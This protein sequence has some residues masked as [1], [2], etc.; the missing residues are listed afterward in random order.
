MIVWKSLLSLGTAVSI[1][2]AAPLARAGDPAEDSPQE[3][4]EE[5]MRS[6]L[7][8]LELLLMSIPQYAAPEVLPNGDIIIRRVRP[9]PGPGPDGGSAP[10]AG[11]AAT[12]EART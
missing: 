9:E 5:G 11:G 2:L 8:A 4:L 3:M 6:I 7:G 12:D 10:P 1:V